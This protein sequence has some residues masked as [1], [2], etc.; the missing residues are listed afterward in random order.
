MNW[1]SRREVKF[2]KGGMCQVIDMGTKKRNQKNV[3]D[4]RRWCNGFSCRN[5]G[6]KRH[7]ENIPM[8]YRNSVFRYI[9]SSNFPECNRKEYVAALKEQIK[10]MEEGNGNE[11][12]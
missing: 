9:D 2:E 8:K 4:S 11:P 3:V 6:C 7:P 1:L 12:L 5:K 10:R